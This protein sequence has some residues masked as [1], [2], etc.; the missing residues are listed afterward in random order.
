MIGSAAVALGKVLAENN[1]FDDISFSLD[2]ASE[3]E[4]NRKRARDFYKTWNRAKTTS[5]PLVLDL[6]GDGVETTHQDKGVHFDHA[7]DG[8]AELQ[9][10]RLVRTTAC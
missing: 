7:G 1:S 6:D 10:A 3:S 4:S 9:P 8:F 2:D 5:S